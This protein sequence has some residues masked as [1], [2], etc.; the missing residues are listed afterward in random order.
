MSL[1][2]D[3]MLK[4]KEQPDDADE[5]DVEAFAKPVVVEADWRWAANCDDNVCARRL[6][7]CK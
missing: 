5:A 4:M 6:I 3:F 2:G 7:M 1:H